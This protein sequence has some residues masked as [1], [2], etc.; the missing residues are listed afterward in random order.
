MMRDLDAFIR[1]VDLYPDDKML[2]HTLPGISNSGGNL[3]LHA[4][5]NLQ[6]F[7][8]AILGGSGYV[9]D[10]DAEFS[11]RSGT[12]EEVKGEL[13]R[14]REII[15][16]VLGGTSSVDLDQPYPQ[17]V[18][19]RRFITGPF[20]IHLATHLA[21]H[22]GQTGYLRRT[23]TGENQSVGPVSNAMLAIS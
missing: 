18:G 19:E 7:I 16:R 10:R 21:F 11:R 1:E 13:V 14:T 6:H 20:L 12:R 22:L 15:D 9:R 8:G 2:W 17:P 4:A 5:G 3:A 23:L